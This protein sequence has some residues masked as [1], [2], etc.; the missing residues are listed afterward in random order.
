MIETPEFHWIDNPQELEVLCQKW[1]ALPAVAL[2]TEF[3]RTDT[4]YPK[5]GLLQLN[6]GEETYLIDPLAIGKHQ[7]LSDLLTNPNVVK[8]MHSCSEDLEVFQ[9]C[10]H[11]LPQPVFDTQIA[12]AFA[13]YGIG[14]GYANL[15][16]EMFNVDLP[17][18]ATRSDWL[19]RPLA[20]VQKH[21]AA[22]D[23]EHLLQIYTTLCEKLTSQNKLAWVLDDCQS[24]LNNTTSPQAVNV[25]YYQ[26]IKLAW[27][28]NPRS[29]A[30]LKELCIWRERQARKRNIP[31]NRVLKDQTLFSLART[32]PPHFA[33]LTT[34]DGMTARV[35]KK[36][37]PT[38][39]ELVKKAQENEA[40]FPQRLPKPLPP[41]AGAITKALRDFV[42]QKAEELLLP[43]EVLIKKTD[44]QHLAREILSN[45]PLTL[46]DRLQTGW[47]FEVI[48]QSLLDY[49]CTLN[50]DNVA[51][52]GG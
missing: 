32:R 16:R 45:Q 17:K 10:C 43:P 50:I 48:G 52:Q 23:V 14:V 24:V 27:Q 39:L 34:I 11:V 28:L 7:A 3:V 21:Y 44:L 37:G 8:V 15:L 41:I 31:R 9:G 19:Q 22:L 36:D 47:R 4:F 1:S 5:P 20:E 18:D 38:L 29:L 30:V 40:E 42:V 26:K 35:I 46:S 33:K 2:D 49:A 51:E 6:D 25:D 12:A 13:G